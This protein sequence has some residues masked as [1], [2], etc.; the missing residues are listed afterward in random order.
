MSTRLLLD[1]QDLRSL[2]LRVRDEMGPDAQIVRAERVRTGGIAGFFAREHYELTVEVPDKPRRGTRARPAPEQ[3]HR[4]TGTTAE[5]VGLDALLAAA[6]AVEADPR[7]STAGSAF[8]E[9][10]ASVQRITAEPQADAPAASDAPA[11]PATPDAGTGSGSAERVDPGPAWAPAPAPPRIARPGGSA[12]ASAPSSPPEPGPGETAGAGPS[13]AAETWDAGPTVPDEVRPGAS[14]AALLELGIPTRL[15]AAFDPNADVPLSGLVRTFDRPRGTH[16]VPGTMVVVA[17]P[18]ELA[19]RTA[20]QMAQRAGLAP[21]DVVLAGEV[22][23]LPGHGRRVQTTAAA[24]RLRERVPQDA[25]LVVALGVAGTAAGALLLDSLA[26]DEAWAAVDARLRGVQ[27]RRW[28]RAVGA[29]RPFDA[30]AAAHTFD[31]QAPGTVLNLGVPVGWLDGLPAS[32]V[33]WAAV[34]GER[35]ADDARWD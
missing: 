8:A 16:L 32:P 15:L 28:L 33:V 26:P 13:D 1:G 25:P 6:D 27:I 30:V 10:L 4:P 24:G 22:D 9:V 29:R 7:V 21:H 34:L 5:P 14:V 31:A 12:A 23:A 3:A 18:A 11:A 19:V 20:T 17:G 35:L 2:M